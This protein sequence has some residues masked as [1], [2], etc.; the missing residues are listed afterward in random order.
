MVPWRAER[1]PAA[2]TSTGQRSERSE[3]GGASPR[4]ATAA[5]CRCAPPPD[6]AT[7]TT[8]SSPSPPPATVEEDEAG[9]DP[10]SPSP[11]VVHQRG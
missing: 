4:V 5:R 10:S 9:E 1:R 7:P 2:A 8:G 11:R 3:R 6:P